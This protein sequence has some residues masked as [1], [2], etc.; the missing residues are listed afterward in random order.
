MLGSKSARAGA[1]NFD[2]TL[3]TCRI[4]CLDPKICPN[5]DRPTLQD[6]VGHVDAIFKFTI[7]L[8]FFPRKSSIHEADH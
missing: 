6:V 2:K 4:R 8:T 7:R 3:K 5:S 1:T